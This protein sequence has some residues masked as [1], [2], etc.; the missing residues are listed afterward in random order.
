MLSLVLGMWLTK[1]K[2]L[3]LG[4]YINKIIFDNI[5]NQTNKSRFKNL[6]NRKRYT[7]RR[8]NV[9]GQPEKHLQLS[10]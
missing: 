7:R 5:Y 8:P 3:L 10:D 2:G 9:D 1:Y 4:K 6:K